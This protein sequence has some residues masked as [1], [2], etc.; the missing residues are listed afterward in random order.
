MFSAINI[1]MGLLRRDN[2]LMRSRCAGGNPS[3]SS[4]PVPSGLPSSGAVPAAHL[5]VSA[6]PSWRAQNPAEE[7]VLIAT[8]HGNLALRNLLTMRSDH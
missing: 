2:Q 1:K 3:R 7:V 8:A 6:D 4:G 5:S